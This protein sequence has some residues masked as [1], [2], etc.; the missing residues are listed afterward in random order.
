MASAD[1]CRATIDAKRDAL[2]EALIGAGASWDQPPSESDDEEQWSPRQVAEHAIGAERTFAGMIASV[3]DAEA[4][5]RQELSLATVEEAI[6][7]LE[8]AINDANTVLLGLSDDDLAIEAREIGNFPPSVEG[9]L[10]LAAYHLDDH[11]KQI[12]AA[13]A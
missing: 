3:T 9:I 4:P 13:S 11:S 7:A 12:A 5:E 8:A 10:Q 6:A 1:E 2:R